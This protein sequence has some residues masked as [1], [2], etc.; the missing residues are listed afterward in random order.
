[1][2]AGP[3]VHSVGGAM[4]ATDRS[5]VMRQRTAPRDTGAGVRVVR[6]LAAGR[7]AL[8]AGLRRRS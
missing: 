1:M 7:A 8:A 2:A 3:C 4:Q 5:D 6:P